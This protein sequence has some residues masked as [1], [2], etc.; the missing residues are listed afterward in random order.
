[1]LRNISI[2]RVTLLA[3]T[4]YACLVLYSCATNYTGECLRWS[5]IETTK[6]HCTRYPN[7]VCF[8]EVIEKVVCID[9]KKEN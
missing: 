3:A 9:R 1:M 2:E 8:D 4:I 5:T 6:T 7:R